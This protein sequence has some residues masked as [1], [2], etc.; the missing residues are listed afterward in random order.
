MRYYRH[1]EDADWDGPALPDGT[2]FSDVKD[3]IRRALYEEQH[4]LCAYCM[5]E[6]RLEDPQL[7]IEHF[8]PRESCKDELIS[9]K[10]DY[11]NLL[12]C[13]N[14]CADGGSVTCDVC[15]G[16][17]QLK[18]IPNPAGHHGIEESVSYETDGRILW[19]GKHIDDFDKTLNLNCRT[20]KYLRMTVWS[21]YKRRLHKDTLKADYLSK[22]IDKLSNPST[23]HWQPFVGCILYHLRRKYRQIKNN[24]R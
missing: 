17:T 19:Q 16:S 9:W 7:R 13:C 20:L 12:L 21:A 24:K 8:Y 5:R 11:G 6:L 2:T 15:K 23:S 10:L 22:Q 18:T 1:Q 4:G 3:K 14:G